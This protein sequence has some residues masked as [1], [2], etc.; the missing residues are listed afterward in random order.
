[1]GGRLAAE[2]HFDY[3]T[4]PYGPARWGEHFP[5][6]NGSKQSPIKFKTGYFI[7]DSFE[8][9]NFFYS[10]T[11]WTLYNTGHN[12]EASP[13]VEN[14][15]Y[16][17]FEGSRYNLKQFHY[18]VG[19]EHLFNGA[20]M[21][22]EMHFVHKNANGE[23]LVI[24]VALTTGTKINTQYAPFLPALPKTKGVKTTV[25]TLINPIDLLPENHD[26]YRYEGSLTTPPCYEGV[27][28]N[29]Y[30][31][32]VS[33]SAAQIN[34]LKSVYSKNAR[35]ARDHGSRPVIIVPE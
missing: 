22:I 18:H 19:S 5:A 21:P 20:T 32:G 23:L 30:T 33:I 34:V 26:V 29:V 10:P 13:L 27:N 2:M 9:I 15:N 16:I 31:H 6:C 24:G 7:D 11:K 14:S 1:V 35:P 28:W 25:Q 17:I 8:E 4:G 3:S 12:V